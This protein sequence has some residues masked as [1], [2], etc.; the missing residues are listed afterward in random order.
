MN[1]GLIYSLI[2]SLGLLNLSFAQKYV[3]P[4]EPNRDGECNSGQFLDCNDNCYP[5]AY[6]VF[7]NN[8]FCDDGTYGINF[9]CERWGFDGATCSVSWDGDIGSDAYTCPS[10]K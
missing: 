10:Q 7:L 3:E 5:D 1:K 4:S 9:I 6:L 2:I 8:D